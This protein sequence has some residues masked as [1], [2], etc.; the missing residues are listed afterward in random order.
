[1]SAVD[2]FASALGAVILIAVVM[3]PYF[4]NVARFEEDARLPFLAFA[5][6]WQEET[7][8]VDL[9]IEGP[10]G[11]DGAPRANCYEYYGGEKSRMSRR[12]A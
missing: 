2:L 6:S 10:V 11:A 4:L 9:R 1:M 3:F 5:L 8:D 12:R 7:A